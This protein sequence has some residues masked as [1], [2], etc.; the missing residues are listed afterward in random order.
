MPAAAPF[1]Y[2]FRRSDWSAKPAKYVNA[3]NWGAVTHSIVHWPGSIGVSIGTDK[4]TIASYLRGWQTY[5][6]G[7]V[8][9]CRSFS[10][11]AARTR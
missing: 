7:A 8:G 6:A 11:W 4:A 3:L 1:T 9:R 10:S 2:D 5:Q